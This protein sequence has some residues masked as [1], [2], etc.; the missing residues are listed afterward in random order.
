[1][2]PEWRR[3]GGQLFFEQESE[4]RV[5]DIDTRAAL[6]TVSPEHA[7]VA[8]PSDVLGGFWH[9]HRDGERFLVYARSGATGAPPEIHAIFNWSVLGS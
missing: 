9:P 4:I 3:S 6:P 8:I 2:R 7:L 1:M 5:V